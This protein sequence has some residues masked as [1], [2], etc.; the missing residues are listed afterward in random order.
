MGKGTSCR[1]GRIHAIADRNRPGSQTGAG[2]R[3]RQQPEAKLAYRF[4]DHHFEI[5]R[6]CVKEHTGITLSEHKRDLC[7]GR[8]VRR[9]RSLGLNNFDAYC[10]LIT[11]RDGR[12]LVH[13]VNAMTTN[14]T[15]FF[16]EP[17]HFEYMAQVVL[18]GLFSDDDG[19]RRV[20]IWSAGC[21]SGEEA[22][23][24]AMVVSEN[25]PVRECW[26][27][28][29]LATDIDSNVLAQAE[30]GIYN[31]THVAGIADTR[32]RRWFVRGTRQNEGLVK[33]AESLRGRVT[34]RRLNLLDTWPMSGL[35]DIIFCRNVVIYFD[36][37][38]QVALFD[39]MA[40]LLAAEGCLFIGHSESLFRVS[41]RFECV[42]RTAYRKVR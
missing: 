29:V 17:H 13:F 3:S 18:P 42:A 19:D 33:V 10:D 39:R 37:A 20:R 40:D 4:T 6:R 27:V 14:M 9:L 8:L 7:Y 36:R 23:S 16:R 26:D 34:F 1:I 31:S 38:T 35:F 5:L 41:D 2:P 11:R 15:A 21:S 25:V 28:K 12:E 24:I 32:L 30:A 22:Y